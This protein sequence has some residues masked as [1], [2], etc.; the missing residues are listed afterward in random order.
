MTAPI[1][2]CE[3]C[4]HTL[5]QKWSTACMRNHT[6]VSAPLSSWNWELRSAVLCEPP[7]PN[8]AE[9][10]WRSDAPLGAAPFSSI[11][12]A[13]AGQAGKEGVQFIMQYS[14]SSRLLRPLW[15]CAGRAPYLG[16]AIRGEEDTSARGLSSLHALR[17]GGARGSLSLGTRSRAH[18]LARHCLL[19]RSMEAST[20]L[21]RT[22]EAA[23]ALRRLSSAA[24]RCAGL[25]E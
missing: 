25:L 21:R 2:L 19:L 14:W 13:C 20:A 10:S 15:P 23:P 16:N 8:T 3:S 12:S 4:N 6:C 11:A 9:R 7:R 22:L 18:A 1:S 5:M 24:C 17:G